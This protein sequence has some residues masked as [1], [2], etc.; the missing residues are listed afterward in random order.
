MQN[1]VFLHTG[2]ESITRTKSI[3]SDPQQGYV[4]LKILYCGVCG[5]DYS[6]YLGRRGS[7]PVTLGHEFVGEIVKLGEN[8]INLKIGDYVVSDLNFRCG[9]CSNCHSNKSH[10]CYRNDEGL[11]S[12]KGFAHYM[13]IHNGYLYKI[14]QY[15]NIKRACLAEPLSCVIHACSQLNIKSSDKILIVGG[16]SI[17]TMF[18]FLLSRIYNVKNI[19]LSESNLSRLQ[20]LSSHFGVIPYSGA[21]NQFDLIVECSNNTLGTQTALDLSENGQRICIMSHLYGLDTSFIYE[22]ICKKELQVI[23]PLRNGDRT[24]MTLAINYIR[25]YW[26]DNDD[27]LFC[28]K[29]NI[30][31][32]FQTNATDSSN[33]QI[34]EMAL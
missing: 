34:V 17:G 16:G 2:V 3:L 24:N 22:A 6:F 9:E 15:K 26:E 7:Y 1:V 11:F 33:K 5:S 18:S 25:E 10:L 27:A 19:I 12:N 14:E 29:K 21:Y 8:V 28:V 20:R 23:F 4:C 31:E 30:Y 32:S 13:N